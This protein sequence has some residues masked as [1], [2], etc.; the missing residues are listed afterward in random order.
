MTHHFEKIM[1]KKVIIIYKIRW[2]SGISNDEIEEINVSLTTRIYYSKQRSNKS[3]VSIKILAT[4]IAYNKQKKEG[5]IGKSI[6][7]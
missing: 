4:C 5:R 2:N 7:E 3:L 1:M 6:N